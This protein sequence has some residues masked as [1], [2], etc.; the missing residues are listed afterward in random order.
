MLIPRIERAHDREQQTPPRSA[1]HRVQPHTQSFR[2]HDECEDHQTGQCADY[3][4]QNQKNLSLTLPQF[5]H[6]R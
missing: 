2:Q 1:A 5:A 6:A 4:P 3:Q